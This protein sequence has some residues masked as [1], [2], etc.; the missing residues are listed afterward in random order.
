[1]NSSLINFLIAIKNAANLNKEYLSFYYSK[2][3]L[4]I[5]K[6]LYKEGLIQDFYIKK[7]KYSQIIIILKYSFFDNCYKSLTIFSKPSKKFFFSYKDI[8]KLY[9]KHVL[10]IF[11]TNLG[12]LTSLECKQK[13]IGGILFFY[14]K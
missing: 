11:S 14:V 3:F 7:S 12:Y 4:L 9:E 8:S 5:A 13:K 10:Y 1:M 2:K 6:I